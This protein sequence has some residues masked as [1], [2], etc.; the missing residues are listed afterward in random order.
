MLKRREAVYI[1]L[2]Y[3]YSHKLSKDVSYRN[4]KCIISIRR[5]KVLQEIDT[6]LVST[7]S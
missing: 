1:I 6:T 7:T 2:T 4:T 3:I 5:K